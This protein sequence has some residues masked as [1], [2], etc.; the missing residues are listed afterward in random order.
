MT[1]EE[2]GEWA[3]RTELAHGD[4]GQ[5]VWLH[6]ALY[7]QE[8]GFDETFEAYVAEPLGRFV[9]ERSERERIWL[10]ER[11]GRIEGVVAVV[12]AADEVA[13][14]R[15]FLVHPDARGRGLGRL[16]LREAVEFARGSG[17]GEIFLWTVG[18]LRAAG[19]LYEQAG[20][21][22]EQ[23]VP[24]RRWGKDVVEERYSLVLR[25]P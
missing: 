14:L 12:R 22:R 3:L 16:L 1:R 23:A 6:G 8:Y 7:A 5:I 4:I 11:A 19:R 20:F 13:Q 17:Y 25:S 10:A 9:I 18:E 21:V 15:W 24:G 2:S